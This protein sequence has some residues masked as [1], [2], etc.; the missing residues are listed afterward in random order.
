MV[1]DLSGG[2]A[3]ALRACQEMGK[4]VLT[5]DGAF[6]SAELAAVE[7]AAFIEQHAITILN[8][9][10][11]RESSHGG[12]ADFAKRLISVLLHHVASN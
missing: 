3:E 6:K 8:V 10:G 2:C 9:A 1:A 4:P 12:A 5:I 11:P 7:V